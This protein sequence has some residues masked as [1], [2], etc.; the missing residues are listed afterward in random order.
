MAANEKQIEDDE[1]VALLADSK[2]KALWQ[3]VS[4][5]QMERKK[6][7]EYCT[8]FGLTLAAKKKLDKLLG[9]P[10]D[11]PPTDPM[12]KINEKKKAIG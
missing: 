6:W 7:L 2:E 1:I 4:E 9:P 3:L 10:S 8:E 11:N 5:L 12:D